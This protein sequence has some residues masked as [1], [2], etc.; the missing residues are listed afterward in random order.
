MSILGIDNRTENWKTAAAFAPCIGESGREARRRVAKFLAKNH[1][2]E[3]GPDEEVKLELFWFGMRDF[4]KQAGEPGR[5]QAA[6]LADRYNRMFNELR[7][8]IDGFA[9]GGGRLRDLNDNAYR[10]ETGQQRDRL[11]DNLQH[12]E[13]DVVLESD[14]CLF[15]GE[16][17]DES[18]FDAESTHALVHQL[19]REYVMASILVDRLSKKKHIIPFV[20]WSR[21]QQERKQLQVQFM[22]EQGWLQ[23][24]N[25]LTWQQVAGLINRPPD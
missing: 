10:A 5:N 9:G 3:V 4:L 11:Y 22:I 19:I 6:D 20:V 13:I 21:G 18:P 15:I 2:M 1:G 24:D 25:L 16:A 14:G 8:D 7:Q 12:T 17:K 23:E